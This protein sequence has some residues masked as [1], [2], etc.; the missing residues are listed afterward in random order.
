MSEESKRV[1]I[2]FTVD[3][4]EVPSRI[5]GLLQEVEEEWTGLG[6]QM[7]ETARQLKEHKN[8]QK[9]YESVDNIRQTMMGLD[10]R[11]EDCQALLASLQSAHANINLSSEEALQPDEIVS[12]END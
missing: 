11:L 2:S 9:S 4:D 5:S 12:K 7:R 1:R 8:I 6:A 3:L 10:L